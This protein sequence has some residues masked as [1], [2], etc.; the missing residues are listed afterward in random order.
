MQSGSLKHNKTISSSYNSNVNFSF[1]NNQNNVRNMNKQ[2]LN[3]SNNND[4]AQ[5]IDISKKECSKFLAVTYT[6]TNSNSTNPNNE[7]LINNDNLTNHV[8]VLF[9]IYSS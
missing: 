7:S 8:W 6:P 9:F 5:L 1:G 2:N 4:S 3:H